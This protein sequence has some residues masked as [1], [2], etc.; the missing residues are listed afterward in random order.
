MR[1]I[2][3]ASGSKGN[4]TLVFSNKTY[5]LIDIGINYSRVLDSLNRLNLLPSD[6]NAILLTHEHI[7]HIKGVPTFI[8][9]NPNCKIY[10]HKN[11]LSTF[12]NKMPTVNPNNFCAFDGE[13]CVNTFTVKPFSVSHDS[14]DC[15]GYQVSEENCAMAIATDLGFYN[16]EI[17]SYL[18][19]CSLVI[20]EANHDVTTLLKNPKYPT[21]LKAR[22]LSNKGHL[23]NLQSAEV[24]LEL[25]KSKVKQIVLAH[26]SEE[27][28]SPTLAYTFIT[29]YLKNYNILEGRD[30]FIDVSTQEKMGTYFEIG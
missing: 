24:I 9:K 2:T 11:N 23:S 26:L 13:F 30:I 8:K 10:V 18:K 3:L 7:D 27:N 21:Y 1:T 16:D 19:P 20:L 25:C 22:I 28:N 29:N 6:I 12:M 15:V 14:N 4:C 17:L 5:L